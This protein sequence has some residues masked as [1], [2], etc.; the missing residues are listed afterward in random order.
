MKR[1]IAITQ[2]MIDAYGRINGDNDIVTVD[3]A[4][5]ELLA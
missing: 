5:S 3:D 1:E 2:D 4:V